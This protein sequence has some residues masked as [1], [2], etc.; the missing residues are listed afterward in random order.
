MIIMPGTIVKNIN[1]WINPPIMTGELPDKKDRKIAF[2]VV[3]VQRKFTGGSIP[4][5][6]NKKAIDTINTVA[7]MFRKN[8]RPVIFVCF[9]GSCNCSS[10]N[11]DDG[12]EYISGI[13]SDPGDIVVHKDGMNSFHQS[14]LADVIKEYRCD[15]VLIAGMVTQFCVIGTYYGAFD[16]DISPY[17]LVD[18]T[19]STQKKFNDAAYTLCKTFTLEDVEEN[20]NNM[21]NKT[22]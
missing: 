7:A 16:H 6:G 3:D 18:G 5:M 11:K 10:Y 2:A 20:I 21:R 15:S 13:V 1:Y 9:D 4:I 22:Q 8:R 19:I 17:L 12:D 14:R